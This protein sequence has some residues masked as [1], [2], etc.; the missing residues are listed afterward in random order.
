M[1]YYEEGFISRLVRF[2]LNEKEALVYFC[3][4][5]HG[6]KNVAQLTALTKGYR[7]AI[8]RVLESLTEK[9]LIEVSISKPRV[10]AAVPLSTA[11]DLIMQRRRNELIQMESSQAEFLEYANPARL[12]LETPDATGKFR[13]VS[14]GN[15]ILTTAA[16]MIGH[17]QHTA[18]AV[19]RPYTVPA[20][21]YSGVLDAYQ[22]AAGRGVEIRIVTDARPNNFRSIQE[23]ANVASVRCHHSYTGILFFTADE[24][25]SMTVIPASHQRAVDRTDS[26]FWISN[27][28]YTSYLAS[29]F[30][31]VWEQAVPFKTRVEQ[32]YK[33][34]L[35]M[36]PLPPHAS[37]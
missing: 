29:T 31:M 11:L 37:N 8:Y 10:F 9:G 1:S 16:Q 17:A 13:F 35:D 23:L 19:I 34:V 28:N 14:G 26:A 20:L 30:D 6:A 3:L 21:E 12:A 36:K 25:E 27:V 7:V 2:G 5:K 15:D 24:D 4:L 22:R 32:I 33:N 18:L